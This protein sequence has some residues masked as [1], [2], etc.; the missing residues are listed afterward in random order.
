[1]ATPRIVIPTSIYDAIED[2]PEYVLGRAFKTCFIYVL[3]AVTIMYPQQQAFAMGNTDPYV[4][5]VFMFF[6]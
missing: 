5:Q 3:D 1:M 4:W 2:V 6:K